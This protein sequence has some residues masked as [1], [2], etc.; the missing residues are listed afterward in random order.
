MTRGSS[1]EPA[2]PYRAVRSTAAAW[3]LAVES[4]DPS[5]SSHLL[6]IAGKEA[7][8]KQMTADRFSV[9]RMPPHFSRRQH[10][11]LSNPRLRSRR[12]PELPPCRI[13]W[14]APFSDFSTP[15]ICKAPGYH[16]P[17]F[18]AILPAFHSVIQRSAVCRTGICSR[19]LRLTLFT[20]SHA[21]V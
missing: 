20:S 11:G 21:G 18:S 6:L 14:A 3:R 9:F 19:P 10:D 15:S 4:E 5:G 13:P 2:A 7:G 16:Q 12:S 8:G 1:L 17:P